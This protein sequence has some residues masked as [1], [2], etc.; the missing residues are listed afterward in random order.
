M[1]ATLIAH[2]EK[3]TAANGGT[4]NAVDSTGANFG[5]IEVCWYNGETGEVTVNDN[6]GNTWIPLTKRT[7]GIFSLQGWYCENP[8]VESGHT[9]SATGPNTFPGIA[10]QFFAFDATPSGSLLN[11]GSANFSSQSSAQPGSFTPSADNALIFCSVGL[12]DN[13]SGTPA[14]DSG[15]S[16]YA[17]TWVFGTSEGVG[18]G[19]L[20]QTTAAAVNPTWTWTGASTGSCSIDAFST[21][22]SPPPPPA[23]DGGFIVIAQQQ[24]MMAG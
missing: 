9:V 8:T 6:K 11:E 23:A 21:G 16:G 2:T 14:I 1:G 15:F 18:L 4:T 3:F 5:R 22:G 7:N 19:F 12:T 10:V 20:A 17:V 13:A 24:L